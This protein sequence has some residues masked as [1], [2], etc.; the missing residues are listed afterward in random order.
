[1]SSTSTGSPDSSGD[2]RLMVVEAAGTLYGFDGDAMR[3]IVPLTTATRIPGAPSYVLGLLN[4]R[5]TILTVIDFAR[6][7]AGDLAAVREDTASVV[8]VQGGGRLLGIAV[9]EVLDVQ[10]LSSSHVEPPP[11]GLAG[12][13]PLSRGL[14]HF[15]DR[16]VIVVDVDELVRQVLV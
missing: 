7:V 8:V 6:R 2:V 3:E 12:T 16:V 11:T 15:G 1:M 10:V 13:G 5:G 9:D 4:V 14:G